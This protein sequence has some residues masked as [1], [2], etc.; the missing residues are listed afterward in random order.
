MSQKHLYCRWRSSI[1]VRSLYV[2]RV[3]WGLQVGAVVVSTQSWTSPWAL[4]SR[5]MTTVNGTGQSA[6]LETPRTRPS[7][8]RAGGSG[9]AGDR[10]WRACSFRCRFR[11][12]WAIQQTAVQ[13]QDLH[14]P[15]P[16][17]FHQAVDPFIEEGALMLVARDQACGHHQKE[18]QV[19]VDMDQ[20]DDLVAPM[21]LVAFVAQIHGP[22]IDR[23]VML[24][25][26][27]YGGALV[28]LLVGDKQVAG[29][30][31]KKPL[32]VEQFQGAE[33][34]WYLPVE[35]FL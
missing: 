10:A 11:S 8:V 31:D 26:Q 22:G 2:V 5:L 28:V 23:M 14:H 18:I 24:V 35:P 33:A 7:K 29:V 19:A 17:R 21:P 12:R 9:G 30:A 3:C 32:R 16:E 4:I 34:A 15:P 13:N 27:H 20:R 1:A 25:E 6:Q